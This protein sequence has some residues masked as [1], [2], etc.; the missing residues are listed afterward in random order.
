MN[1]TFEEA[2]L[3]SRLIDKTEC[4][5]TPGFSVMGQPSSNFIT[6]NQQGN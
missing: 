3:K 5:S 1:I 2:T 6:S 4:I